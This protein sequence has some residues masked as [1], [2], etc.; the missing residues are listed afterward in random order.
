MQISFNEIKENDYILSKDGF[1]WLEMDKAI[2]KLKAK[3]PNLMDD[4]ISFD[5]FTFPSSAYVTQFTDLKDKTPL[6]QIGNVNDAEWVISD[7]QKFEY[8]PNKYLLSKNKYLLK[9]EY[10]LISLTGGSNTANDI[11]SYFDASFRGFLNQRV[12]AFSMTKHNEDLFFFFYALTKSDFFKNQWLGKGG[13]QKNTVSKERDRTY[14]PKVSN[15][16][17]VKYISYLIQAV[18]NK[19]R[20]IKEHHKTI[21]QYIEKELRTNQK[22]NKYKF[23]YP[24][25]QELVDKGRF[26]TGLYNESFKQ[27]NFLVTN[28]KHGSKDLISRGFNW[29]RGTSLEK[30][31]I[32]TRIDSDVYHPGFYELVLP[33][34]ISQYGY[35]DKST[36]IGTPTELK[37]ISQGD[38]I[39]G[40]EGFGKGRT[41][42]VVE[43]S[44]NVATNYHGIRIINTNNNLTE[45]IFIR[46]FLAFWRSKGM[47]DFIGVGGSGGHCAPSYFHLIETPLF[48][49]D[50]QKEIAYLYHNDNL[51]YNVANCSL[52]NFL[53]TDTAYNNKAGIY[54]LDKTAKQLKEK[55]Y[56]AIDDIINNREVKVKFDN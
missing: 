5:G 22:T 30:N 12:G 8:V 6:I 56:Q 55:L 20:L 49:D 25:I 32:R 47:I 53:Q 37:T 38:I 39:F 40:G 33:T 17:A 21:F 15:S 48:P 1:K 4:F 41:Y 18:I 26:D 46:C 27:L 36:F 54:E 52:A 24:T 2:D 7:A 28:Y 43:N 23:D 9:T 44:D 51:T 13:I 42:V 11:T 16:N 35:V 29:Q 14:I 10:I 34:N 3:Y 31:F 19:E 50:K 45:S